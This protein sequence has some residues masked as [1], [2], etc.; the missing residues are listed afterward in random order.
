MARSERKKLI[1]EIE[2]KRG[3]KVITYVTSDRP[4]FSYQIISDIV[5]IMHEHILN[6]E[7]DDDDL[8]LDLFIYSRGGDSNVPWTVV[9]MFREYSKKGSFSVLVPFRAHS[10][11]TMI[12]LGADEIVMSKKAELGPIDI[13]THDHYNPQ[14]ERTGK[15]LPISVEDVNGYFDLL[16]EAGCENSDQTVKGFE[17][18]AENVHPLAL[19][20]VS[21]LLKQTKL[22]ATRLLS[23]RSKPFTKDVNESIVKKLSSE[24]YSHQHAISRT[25]AKKYIGLKQVR[26]AEKDSIDKDLWSLYKEYKTLFKLEE[27]LRAEEYLI[28]NNID[29]N[30]WKD[31]NLACI[32]SCKRLDIFK[33]DL[34]VRIIRQVPPEIQINLSNLNL[35]QINIPELSPG[36]KPDQIN[37]LIINC[38]NSLLP[39]ALKNT[40][41]LATKEI[42][43]SLPQ[44]G[45]EHYRFNSRWERS[46]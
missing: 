7:N 22:V 23:T 9:S 28:S 37:Q 5:P 33:Q 13:T 44:A 40:I 42:L 15:R 11:A 38:V 20:S 6:L 30:Q 39:T 26:N 45:F 27:P 3:S 36:M 2:E 14:D 8:K 29:E 25:E 35:P 18:L 34:S 31:L 1:R 10:A 43:K 4:D 19:G 41:P 12:A 21:R 32:E 16:K 24:I 46:D 17:L